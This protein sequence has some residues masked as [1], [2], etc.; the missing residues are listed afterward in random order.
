[1]EDLP[2]SLCVDGF[3]RLGGVEGLGEVDE[4]LA[5]TDIPHLPVELLQLRVVEQDF[6]M[7]LEKR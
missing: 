6:Q 4:C 5:E 2:Q 3:T 1:M 7:L